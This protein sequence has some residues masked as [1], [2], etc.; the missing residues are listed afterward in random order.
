M[1]AN[2]TLI[3]K[4]EPN[5][6]R[7]RF[8]L[9]L[10]TLGIFLFGLF[11]GASRLALAADA[12]KDQ[13]KNAP[14]AAAKPATQT[15]PSPTSSSLKA[16]VK[17]LEQKDKAASKTSLGGKKDPPPDLP[18]IFGVSLDEIPSKLLKQLND[19]GYQQTKW[20]LAAPYTHMVFIL[21]DP[22][23]VFNN[24][25]LLICNHP[26]KIANLKI[27][28]QDLN[29]FYKAVKERFG[30]TPTQWEIDDR[31]DVH[32]GKYVREF[33]GHNWTIL[34]SSR[35]KAAFA[36]EARDIKASCVKALTE[37]MNALKNTEKAQLQQERDK[38][39]KS[40]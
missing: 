5:L 37:D 22:M 19:L 24:I 18:Q 3:P 34:D 28:G 6:G 8:L 27:E 21:D 14:T 20:E 30:F 31:R 35:K 38:M 2:R 33:A 29:T 13:T 10:L 23:A 32:H 4:R 15:S 39:I 40:F 26:H 25:D 11:F 7:P 1:W 12:P 17:D 9:G 16:D 36:I